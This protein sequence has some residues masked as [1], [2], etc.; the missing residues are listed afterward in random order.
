M[1]ITSTQAV[2]NK[3]RADISNKRNDLLNNLEDESLIGREH[4]LVIVRAVT[5]HKDF[6]IV[7]IAHQSPKMATHRSQIELE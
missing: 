4:T 1:D 7:S 5:G 3:P 6:K 2:D